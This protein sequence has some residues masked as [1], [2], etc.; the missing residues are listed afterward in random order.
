MR[1]AWRR[2]IAIRAAASAL[3]VPRHQRARRIVGDDAAGAHHHDAVGEQHRLLDIVGDHDGGHAEPLVQRPVGG[4]Q[5]VAG[6][7]IERAERLVHQHDA[8][9]RRD[10]PRHAGALA[11]ATGQRMGEA[12]RIVARQ[13]DEVEQLRDARRDVAAAASASSCGV[14]PMFSAMVM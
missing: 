3:G 14:M 9:P 8:R 7:R 5:R 1:S 6:D 11:L 10:G 12:R 4:A 2:G 13:L